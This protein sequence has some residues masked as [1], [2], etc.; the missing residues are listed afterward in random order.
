[1]SEFGVVTA[2]GS[3]RFERLLP[4]PIERVWAFLTESDKR[5][6]WFA[7]GALEPRV[8][9]KMELFFKH[10]NLA[11]PGEAV[12]EKYKQA[13]DPGIRA[14]HEI[15]RY[16]PPR[17][18]A[19]TWAGPASEVT[20]ELTPQGDKVRLVLTHERLADRDAMRNVAGGWHS[21]LTLLADRLEG[22]A[23]GPFWPLVTRLHA[24]YESRIISDRPAA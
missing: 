21:H 18:L 9:G 10:A 7:G 12:P 2:P 6:T 4:G 14:M 23:S 8:G 19:F 17:L 5:A 11:Q 20:F 1:M 3:L 16:E 22:R 15:T 13:H 24:E